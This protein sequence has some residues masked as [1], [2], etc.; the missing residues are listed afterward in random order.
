LL[1]NLKILGTI[2]KRYNIFRKIYL[3]NAL[4]YY[5][6]NILLVKN[7]PPNQLRGWVS[8]ATVVQPGWKGWKLC[9]VWIILG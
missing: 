7:K 6:R 4:I 1:I 5:T 3:T 9:S 8:G 2:D